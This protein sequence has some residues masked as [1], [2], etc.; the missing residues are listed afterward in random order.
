MDDI[1]GQRVIEDLQEARRADLGLRLI[2]R[3]VVQAVPIWFVAGAL[4]SRH[5]SLILCPAIGLAGTALCLVLLPFIR[6]PKPLLQNF[7]DPVTKEVSFPEGPLPISRASSALFVS[8]FVLGL[9]LT[10]FFLL[11]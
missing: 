5:H 4:A 6:Y 11:Q 7:T 1:K 9:V 8:C 3:T 10:L 2:R